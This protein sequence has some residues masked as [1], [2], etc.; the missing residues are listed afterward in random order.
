VAAGLRELA[1]LHGVQESYR[2]LRGRRRRASRGTLVAVLRALGAPLDSPEEVPEALRER[3]EELA[4]RPVEPVTPV[5]EGLGSIALNLPPG[6]AP[7]RVRCRLDLEDGTA[8]SWTADV[9]SLRRSSARSLGAAGGATVVLPLPGRLPLGYHRLEVELGARRG[10]AL[11]IS[12]PVRAAHTLPPGCW[13]VFVPLHALHRARGWG[14]GDLADLATLAGSVGELGGTLV[15]TLPL[16]AAFLRDHVEPSPYSP[17]SRLFWNELFLDVEALPEVRADPE[18]RRLMGSAA[19]RREV[20]RL[21]A[22]DLVDHAAVMALKRRVLEPGARA[23][24]SGSSAR[25][26]ALEGFGR[27]RPRLEDYARFRAAGERWGADWRRWPGPPRDGRLRG[28][29]VDPAAVGYHRYVQW[30]TEEQLGGL[31]RSSLYLDLPL[32]VNPDGYDVWRD[33]DAF[34]LGVSAGAPPDA[35]F[36]GGQDWGFP[37]PHPERIREQGYAYHAECLR[38]AMRHAGALRIDHAMGLHR[39]YWV[40]HGFPAD[41]GA[42]VR[43]RPEEWYAIVSLESHRAG[44]TVVGEDLG[45]VPA[46]VRSSM[47]R[48]GVLRS[49]VLQFDADPDRSPPLS[50]PPARSLASLN[51]HDMPPFASFW[52]GLDIAERV[53]HGLLA[54]SEAGV[55]QERRARLRDAVI[56]HLRAAGHLRSR[57]PG[58]GEVLSACLAVLAASPAEAVVVALEDLWG[59]T[60]AQNLPG[61]AEHPSWRRRAA[62]PVEEALGLPEVADRLRLVGALRREAASAGA[63]RRMGRGP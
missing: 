22:G 29:E 56:E 41:R 45:T 11:V 16:Y 4:R 53:A 48:H 3:R 6:R 33:R 46:G 57:R 39:L 18:A 43:H 49:H 38:H 26:E 1:R 63:G 19:F 36:P 13:G 32:G 58:E 14:V 47:R 50:E 62:H 40:P 51:T 44:T 25:R 7:E 35:F 2:D 31:G 23:L 54:A 61:V 55:E 42:Y 34:A 59:E 28:T 5:W 24:L 52:R 21:R 30:A 9:S 20:D 37:P 27:G 17:V 15:G 60:R 12:A 10:A 8:R